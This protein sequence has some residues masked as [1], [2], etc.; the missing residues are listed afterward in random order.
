MGDS[1]GFKVD[2]EALAGHEPEVR[3][4]ATKIQ[5]AIDA[6]GEAQGLF[7]INAFGLVGQIFAGG[8]Q[9]WV[10]T[11]TDFV[12]GLGDAGHTLADKVQ[13]AHQALSTHEENS[14]G[15]LTAIGKDIPA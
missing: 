1:A 2:L 6:T 3:D 10:A 15:M 7:D 13:G 14:K 11:A 4:T 8:I 12:K 9:Y 5:E